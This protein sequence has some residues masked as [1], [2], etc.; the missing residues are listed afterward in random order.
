MELGLTINSAILARRNDIVNRHIILFKISVTG[1]N[2][3]AN[4]SSDVTENYT[5]HPKWSFQISLILFR[6]LKIIFD[7][8]A[9]HVR[10]PIGY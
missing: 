3:F 6:P 1:Q 8:D 10:L 9:A 7:D 4:I 2:W 5:W